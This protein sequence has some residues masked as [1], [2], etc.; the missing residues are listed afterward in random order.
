MRTHLMNSEAIQI[1]NVA[2]GGNAKRE[3]RLGM[4]DL[5]LIAASFT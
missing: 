3:K 1:S 5:L 2:G 4:V